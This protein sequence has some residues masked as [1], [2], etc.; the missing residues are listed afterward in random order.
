MVLTTQQEA[1]TV[2]RT[3]KEPP[4]EVFEPLPLAP[5]Q[6]IRKIHRVRRRCGSSLN[7]QGQHDGAQIRRL[8]EPVPSHDRNTHGPAYAIERVLAEHP[9]TGVSILL[10]S[11]VQPLHCHYSGTSSSTVVIKA[12]PRPDKTRKAFVDDPYQEIAALQLLQHQ[13]KHHHFGGSYSNHVIQLLDCMQD[14]E[15]L[16]LVLPYL[17]GGDLFEWVE[18]SDGKGL[19]EPEVCRIFQ[20]MISGLL[21]MKQTS[22]LAHHDVSLE[23]AVFTDEQRDEIKMIDLGMCIRAPSKM[24]RLAGSCEP[25]VLTSQISRGKPSYIA[26][27]VLLEEPCDPFASDIWSLGVCLYC[28]LTGRPLYN[29]PKDPAFKLMAQGE[30]RQVVAAYEAYGLHLSP[31]AKDLVCRMMSSIP[32]ERPALED[33]LRHPFV[34]ARASGSRAS[35]Q[36]GSV[37]Q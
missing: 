5:L 24:G 14:E 3:K 33:V 26:P 34:R 18:A 12:V 25:V 19:P 4:P 15:F 31:C 13:H 22:G 23:N 32:S 29:S 1:S 16:Y 7:Q 9:K 36:S 11:P 6:P 17:A 30:V 2:C 37:T 28:M 20:Q 10:A 8:L 27:E 21:S 35:G